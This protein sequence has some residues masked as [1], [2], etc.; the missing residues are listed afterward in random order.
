MNLNKETLS[1]SLAHHERFGD[2]DIFPV[3][4][5]YEA[6]RQQWSGVLPQLL[7]LD[8]RTFQTSAYR[9]AMT[10]KSRF[11]FRVATQL[12]PIDSLVYAGLVYEIAKDLE[13]YRDR[14]SSCRVFSHRVSRDPASGQLYEPTWNYDRFKKHLSEKCSE[15]DDGWVVVTDVADFYTRI[16]HHPLENCLNRATDKTEHV[17]AIMNML[18]QWNFAVSSGIP[19]GPAASRILAEMALV[20]VDQTLSDAGIDFCR[21]SDDFRLFA[22]TEQEAH[23]VLSV[24]ATA[25]GESQLTLSERKTDVLS[26]SRHM[27][28]HLHGERA[29]DSASLAG[30]V[31]SILEKY[32][33]ENDVYSQAQLEELPPAMAKELD[34]LNLNEI[35][36]RESDGSRSYDTFIVSLALRRLAQIRD[37]SLLELVVENLHQFTPV[38][39][40]VI[41]YFDRVTPSADRERI[42]VALLE[43]A[44]SGASGHQEYQLAWLLDLFA[45]D[46]RWASTAALQAMLNNTT[47]IMVR[48]KLLEALGSRDHAHW[49]RQHR[50]DAQN[51]SGWELRG[52]V[53]GAQC[54]SADEYR[55]WLGSL[56][57][58]LDLLGR[59]V[60]DHSRERSKSRPNPTDTS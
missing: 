39:P 26:T 6:I 49:F 14:R 30:R 21:F 25:L 52:F 10:P 57:P 11:G 33:R 17:K 3:P 2:T 55:P 12:D 42:G 5:E 27:S 20:D 22:R 24:L 43:A 32:G 37:S 18:S 28:R 1:W 15:Y 44:A 46:T 50:R 56:G 4:L 19:I 59:T 41:N 40:Q 54:L 7:A 60:A 8:M 53:L 58:R 51:L 47:H 9:R 34:E 38:Y 35:L 16:Y 29:D 31:A 48:P 45:L 13:G 36:L 23:R